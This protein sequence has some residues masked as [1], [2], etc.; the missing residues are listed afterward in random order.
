VPRAAWLES[1]AA[2]AAAARASHRATEQLVAWHH[3]LKKNRPDFVAYRLYLETTGQP[4]ESGTGAYTLLALKGV[5]APVKGV[6]IQRQRLL[7]FPL[8]TATRRPLSQEEAARWAAD[9]LAALPD[10]AD[11]QADPLAPLFVPHPVLPGR[12][13]AGWPE[14]ALRPPAASAL[15]ARLRAALAR[16]ARLALAEPPA[17]ALPAPGGTRLLTLE[18]RDPATGLRSTWTA[19]LAFTGTRW[20]CVRL[21]F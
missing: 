11:P 2:E 18:M 16:G 5:V 3:A 10:P 1:L 9:F 15:F 14:P 13:Y 17:P 7:R 21:T 19:R 6:G 20:Q 8:W 12:H 4:G